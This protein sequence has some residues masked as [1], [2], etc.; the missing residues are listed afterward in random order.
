MAHDI[1]SEAGW[2]RVFGAGAVR[3]SAAR[4]RCAR[5]AST[6]PNA[7]AAASWQPLINELPAT[8]GRLDTAFANAGVESGNSIL[9]CPALSRST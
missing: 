8:F 1:T 7:D 2:D 9:P 4:C 3:G 6:G 5:V